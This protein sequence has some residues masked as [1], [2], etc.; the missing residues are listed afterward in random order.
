MEGVVFSFRGKNLP[1]PL[2]CHPEGCFGTRS[3]PRRGRIWLLLSF[4]GAVLARR[5]LDLPLQ[6]KP[7][8]PSR[9]LGMTPWSLSSRTTEGRRDLLLILNGSTPRSLAAAR[10][11]RSHRVLACLLSRTNITKSC[12]SEG[13]SPRNL[14]FGPGFLKP[15]NPR[16]WNLPRDDTIFS[17]IPSERSDRGICS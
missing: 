4:R 1:L 16:Q 3:R 8:D 6:S 7:R 14:D 15:E 12:H 13:R 17:V 11:D 10:D 9:P 5:N 2:P